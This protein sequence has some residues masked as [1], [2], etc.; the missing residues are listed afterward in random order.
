MPARVRPAEQARVDL[1]PA[2]LERLRYPGNAAPVPAVS[3]VQHADDGD[4]APPGVEQQVRR[5]P[6]ALDV[7]H[8]H[9]VDVRGEHLLAEQHE[10]VAEALEQVRVG[11]HEGRGAE[12]QAVDEA[13]AGPRSA[14]SSPRA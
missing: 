4:A 7:A 14:A 5:R 9:V 1:D 3:R 11:L 8:R 10:R 2:R 6:R 12:D 13:A